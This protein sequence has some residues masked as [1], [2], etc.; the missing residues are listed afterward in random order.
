GCRGQLPPVA[1][2]N[3][4][5]GPLSSVQADQDPLRLA[6]SYV[7]AFVAGNG[8]YVFHS[9]P[10]V[11]GGGAFDAARGRPANSDD[12]DPA[13]LDA[14]AAMRQRLPAGLANWDRHEAHQSSMP[15]D[16][17][18]QAIRRGSLV[19]AY[20]ATSGHRLVAVLLGV[21]QPHAITAR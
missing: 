19:G 9:G 17:S 16:G 8:A 5:I 11:R 10:G 21:R 13:I 18:Q 6:L 2:S 3:E 7:T 1:V 14:L 4:P 20:A 12:L 15:W